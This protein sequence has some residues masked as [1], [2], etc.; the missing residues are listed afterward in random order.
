MNSKTL[1]KRNNCSWAK[2]SNQCYRELFIATGHS[3]KIRNVNV[4]DPTM[5]FRD[6]ASLNEIF[7]YPIQPPPQRTSLFH[8]ISPNCSQTL[9]KPIVSLDL[10]FCIQ[11]ALYIQNI[12]NMDIPPQAEGSLKNS[13]HLIEIVIE[14]VEKLI[15][16]AKKSD[17]SNLNIVDQSFYFRANEIIPDWYWPFVRWLLLRLYTS[18]TKSISFVE[19]IDNPINDPFSSVKDVKMRRA[20]LKSTIQVLCEKIPD[21]CIQGLSSHVG[22]KASHLLQPNLVKETGN[23]SSSGKPLSLLKS[24]IIKVQDNLAA[25]KAKSD[26]LDTFSP[27]GYDYNQL[28]LTHKRYALAA[29]EL[30]ALR[31][32][33]SLAILD[34]QVGTWVTTTILKMSMAIMKK[35]KKKVK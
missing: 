22:N 31:D 15:N 35:K 9:V 21:L 6:L 5:G 3:K 29:A 33:E 34:G 14:D 27:D 32:A 23:A 19:L 20:R 1:N 28:S 4:G 17:Y 10:G 13:P 11:H 8:N 24:V 26:Y 2:C 12:F 7:Q 25:K 18:E 16:G 30:K